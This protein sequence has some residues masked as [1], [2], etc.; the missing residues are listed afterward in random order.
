MKFS[1]LINN[2]S[3]CILPFIHQEKKFNGTYHICCYGDQL[4]SDNPSDNSLDS[5]NSKKMSQLRDNMISGVKNSACESCYQQ[6]NNGVYSPRMRENETWINWVDTHSAIESCFDNYYSREEIKPISYDLRYSNTCTLKCRMCNSSSSSALNAEYKKIHSQW[7]EKFWTI[8][9]HRVNHELELHSNI[10]KIYLAGGEPLVEPYNLELLKEVADYNDRLVILINTSLNIV[11]D[12]FLEILNRFK[13][14]TLVVSIDGTNIVND[15]IRHGSSFSIVEEN[16]RKLSHHNMMFSTCVSIYNIFNI[17]ELVEFIALEFPKFAV[18][19]SINL[20]NDV[21]EIVIDNVPYELRPAIIA[22]LEQ[23]LTISKEFTSI[24]IRNVINLLKQDNFDEIRFQRFIKYTKIL[25][26]TRQ[27]SI[28]N[29][30][31]GLAKYFD[32]QS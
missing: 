31:P 20:V 4:Q 18:N 22:D 15:Y 27:E 19:H 28:A 24:G 17:R 26:K 6:E 11:S 8:D 1:N 2:G 13:Y 29:V 5:F 7:P 23:A 14:L 32:E 10:Q 3:F 12:K 9:N 30:V 21:E 25:D 16:I